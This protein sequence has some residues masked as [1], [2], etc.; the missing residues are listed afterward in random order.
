MTKPDFELYWDLITD[1][2]E[3]VCAI[4]SAI[5]D[6][7]NRYVLQTKI[8]ES[9][10]NLRQG[11]YYQD[12]LQEFLMAVDNCK[13]NII[14]CPDQTYVKDEGSIL[15]RIL[16]AFAIRPTIVRTTRLY[17]LLGGEAHC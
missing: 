1:P 6:L 10:L 3:S 4:D 7:R 17:G 9:V 5:K 15:R 16:A 13:G 11:R 8:W 2:N 12:N 14:D